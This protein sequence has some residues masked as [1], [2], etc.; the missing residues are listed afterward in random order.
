MSEFLLNPCR[1]RRFRSS[2]RQKQ[3]I[4]E[5]YGLRENR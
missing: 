2:A 5:I 4:L 1:H 3:E